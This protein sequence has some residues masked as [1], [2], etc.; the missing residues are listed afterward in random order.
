MKEYMKITFAPKHRRLMVAFAFYMYFFL[1]A[2]LLFTKDAAVSIGEGAGTLVYGLF[3]FATAIGFFVFPLL[4]RAFRGKRHLIMAIFGGI[5]VVCTAA[6]SFADSWALAVLA[7]I[8]MLTAGIIGGALL[9]TMA[10]DIKAKTVLGSLIAIPYSVAF[11][12]QYL[13]GY[14][15]PLLGESADLFWHLTIAVAFLLSSLLAPKSTGIKPKEKTPNSERATDT[16]RYLIGAVIGGFI[17]FCLYGMLDG[18]IMTLHTGQQLNPYGWVRLICVP[19]ILVAGWIFDMREGRYF[20]FASAIAMVAAVVAVFLFNT[21]E[22]YNAALG[23]IYF[24]CS[25]MT[26]YSLAV[27]IRVADATNIPEFWAVA[28][29]GLKYLAGGIF[30][31][32]GSVMFTSLNLIFLTLIYLVMLIALFVVFFSQ[33]MLTTADIAARTIPPQPSIPLEERTK[34]YGFTARENET[35]KLLMKGLETDEIADK[36]FISV[37]TVN[38]YISSMIIKADVKSRVGLM[39]LFSNH[40]D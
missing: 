40:K 18:I 33:G 3:C 28:G 20:P 15:V 36:L 31:L 34:S 30:A 9:H 1:E 6:T 5:G 19:G 25:F 12:L 16:K 24:F 22:T 13:F 23:S 14:I 21:A 38:K 29:R 27:F 4:F 10:T 7:L 2:E 32:A 11:I 39:A 8:T 35:L 17:I 26:M 37:N